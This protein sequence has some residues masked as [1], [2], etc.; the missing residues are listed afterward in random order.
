[1]T[2]EVRGLVV[3]VD[4]TRILHG[5]DLV[6]PAW[7]L[8]ALVGPNGSGKSTLLRQLTGVETPTG[9]DVLLDGTS[10]R[11]LGRRERARRIAVVEQEAAS[12]L[13]LTCLEVAMLGRMPH[14]SLLGATSREDRAIAADALA[15]AGAAAWADRSFATLSGGERQRVRLAAALAQEPRILVLD[16]PTNHLDVRASLET[17]ALL[18]SLADDG[19]TVVAALHDLTLAGWA[20]HVALLADGRLAAAGPVAEVLTAERIA[21]V[22]DVRAHVGPDPLTG[23]PAVTVALP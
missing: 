19:V 20:D 8:T 16:E 3:E 7:G 12:E 5:I 17:I 22:Y 6:V 15:R 18:R 2:L 10:L 21:A 9:G 23:R 1:M 4:G 11:T 14:Q 13:A